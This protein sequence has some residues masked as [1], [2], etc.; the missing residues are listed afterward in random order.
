LVGHG[1]RTAGCA[2][3]SQIMATLNQVFDFAKL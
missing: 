1:R 2:I 3:V